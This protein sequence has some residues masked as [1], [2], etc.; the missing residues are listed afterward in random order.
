MATPSL[1][2]GVPAAIIDLVQQG[3]IEREFH[4]GLFPN[5][6]YRAEFEA[7]KWEGNTGTEVVMTRAGLLGDIVTPNT[8]G[9]DPTPQNVPFEQWTMKL[10]QYAGTSDT[11]MPTS[12]VAN[13]NLFVRNIHQLGLQAGRSI[14]RVARNTLFKAYLSGQTVLLAAATAGDSTV[15]VSSMNG[16]TDVVLPATT[17]RPQNVST[18]F[19]LPV[20]FGTG[21]TS[22]S[23]TK[24]VVGFTPDNPNDLFGPGTLTLSATLANSYAVRA[25]VVSAYAPRI[26]RANGGA[27]IDAIGSSD[28][29]SLQQ[30]I[31]S[32][33][34][35]RN[36]NVSPHDDGTFHAHISPLANAQVYA[37]PVFQ[38][39]NQSL[40]EGMTYS[41]G[42][43]GHISG[44]SF[45]M[46]TESPNTLNVGTLTATVAATGSSLKG[47]YAPELGAEIVN[48]FG[49]Q[50][51]R[52]IITG[53]GAGY[54]RYLDESLYVSEAGTT[55]KIG[56][57]SVVNNGIQILTER[58]RLVIRAPLDRLQQKVSASW[59]ISTGFAMPSDITAPSGPERFKRAIVLEFAL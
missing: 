9:T 27:S 6:A 13:S 25:P 19:P 51:G 5:L 2:L 8:P 4:D 43:L 37:D 49:T 1:V 39:L 34:F 20:T 10:D 28:T 42:F 16:F 54:E 59:S 46:N 50:I 21:G 36:A 41:E 38:R 11:D 52:V 7:D 15:R 30:I 55:G 58:I 44:V 31:N 29:L 45:F 48:G 17:A 53:K 40:P 12:A 57:F 35:L 23:E 18:A 56:E 47:Q 22:T 3:L 24:S 26:V 14:N 33:A 32:V